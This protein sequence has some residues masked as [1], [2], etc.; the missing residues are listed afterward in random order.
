MNELFKQ[1]N[2]GII[3]N[4]EP[5]DSSQNSVVKITTLDNEYLVK[6]YSKDAI[7]NNK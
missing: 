4:I 2:L 1:L 3:T 7:K 6:Q 5:V